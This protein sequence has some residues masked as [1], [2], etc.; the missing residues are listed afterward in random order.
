MQLKRNMQ[1]LVLTSQTVQQPLSVLNQNLSIFLEERIV[2]STDQDTSS[3]G[4][5]R[6][7]HSPFEMIKETCDDTR[8]EESNRL[9][10]VANLKRSSR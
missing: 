5:I 10:I 1:P 3:I 6:D 9:K 8:T 7:V 4:V 2:V